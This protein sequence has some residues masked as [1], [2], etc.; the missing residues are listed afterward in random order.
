MDE[1]FFKKGSCF[2]MFYCYFAGAFYF[3]MRQKGA[4]EA[5]CKRIRGSNHKKIRVPKVS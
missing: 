2:N 1:I 5:A 4:A 3:S